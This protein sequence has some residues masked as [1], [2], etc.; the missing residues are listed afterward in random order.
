M[1]TFCF[2]FFLGKKLNL[3][4]KFF[5]YTN[6]IYL[7]INLS[8]LIFLKTSQINK[9]LKQK[10]TQSLKTRLPSN[11]H[12]RNHHRRFQE[13]CHSNSDQRL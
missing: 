5:F 10:N 9:K 2:Y 11:V 6:Q 3:K 8:A 12:Q 13:L 7:K 4:F 1:K